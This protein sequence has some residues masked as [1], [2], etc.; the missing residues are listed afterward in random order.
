MATELTGPVHVI[1]AGLLGTSIGLA[2]SGKGIEV[3][4]S[5]VNHEHVRTAC[6]LGAGSP[7]PADG[8]P[9]LVV[10]S[11]PPDHVAKT[12]VLALEEGDAVVTDVGSVKAGPLEE[13]TDHVAEPQ[14]GRYVGG[15]PMAGNE[16]SGPLAAS[17]SLFDARPWAVTPHVHASEE[18]VELVEA[19]ARACGATPLRLSPVEHD[20]AVA[21]TSH[22]PHLL[23]VLAAGQLTDAQP[24]HLALSGQ[25]VRDVTRVAAGDPELYSQIIRANAPHVRDGL[26]EIRDELSSLIGALAPDISETESAEALE[27]T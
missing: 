13:V 7:L 12:V 18:A 14:L 19:L 16:R 20:H 26:I 3:W 6:S 2:L 9:Q 8:S 17:A 10:V 5:D 27:R 22:L 11:V 24:D 21:R 23:A 25:G 15:H 4:L 1:G